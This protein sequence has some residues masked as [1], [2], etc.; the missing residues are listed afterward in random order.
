MAIAAIAEAPAQKPDR[1]GIIAI[2]LGTSIIA[3]SGVLVRLLDVGSIAGGGWRMVFS[4]PLLGLWASRNARLTPEVPRASAIAPI[5]IASGML[6]A[7]DVASFNLSLTGTSVANASFIGNVS[8]I[9]AMVGG[10]LFFAEHPK[11]VVWFALALALLGSWVMTGMASPSA[12]G[13]GDAFALLA[14]VAYAGYLL[15][16]KLSRRSLDGAGATFWSALS[17][18]PVLFIASAL[19][20][21]KIFPSSLRGWAVVITMGTVSH[22]LGQGLTSVALGRAPV[23]LVAVFVLAQPPVSA[24][25]AYWVFG[26]PMSPVQMIGGAIILAAIVVAR[27]GR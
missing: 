14:A 5:L 3:W 7:L 1:I 13:F 18:A 11:P 8:P 2:V 20:G 16:T 4:L 9:L 22:A 23:A 10:A 24:L 26:E 17:A 15:T 27:P 21:E 6:F 19:H 12:I 25:L